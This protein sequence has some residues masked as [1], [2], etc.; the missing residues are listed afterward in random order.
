MRTVILGSIAVLVAC[1]GNNKS[2]PDALILPPCDYTEA[3]DAT[4]GTMAEMTNLTLGALP[5]DVCGTVNNGHYD[6]AS[7]V[8]DQDTYRI[9][10]AA[11]T[12]VLVQFVGA[13]G[14]E[15]VGDFSVLIF[16]TATQ[17]TLLA[18]STLDSTHG[19]HGVF[20]TSLP[21]GTFDFVVDAKDTIDLAAPIDYKVRITADM[22]AVRC[23]TSIMPADYTEATDTATNTGND[24]FEA[25]FA[26]DPPFTLT[27]STTDVPEPT[28]LTVDTDA[29][30]HITGISGAE[31]DADDYQDHDTYEITTGPMVD[32]LSIRLDWPGATADLD[33]ALFEATTT[34]ETGSALLTSTTGPEFDTFAV[35]PASKY[36]VWV[37]A[38]DGSTGQPI[39]YDLEL[40]AAQTNFDASRTN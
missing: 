1:G 35:K 23:P 9:T 11:P 4:N 38:H 7:Q 33:Y 15:T 31:D 39:M 28:G 34:S 18:G 36:W 14:I 16:D 24:V 13:A 27:A 5:S 37:A 2:M 20:L 30:R 32:E 6:A 25:K 12:D 40:C 29:N 3:T 10:L 19:S 8:V 21:A 26:N 22:P 17:P